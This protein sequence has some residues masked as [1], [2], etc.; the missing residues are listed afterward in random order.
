MQTDTIQRQYDEVIA[1]HYDLDPQ[2][3]TGDSL[4]KAVEQLQST[5]NLKQAESALRI[6]DVGCGTGMFCERLRNEAG[7]SIDPYGLDLSQAMVDIAGERI[8]DMKLAVDDAANLDDHFQDVSFNIICTH[9]MTGFVPIDVL[10]PKIH[11]KL[12]EGGY[13]SF[14]GG[15]MGGFPNLQKKADLK[16]L[17]MIFGGK[18]IDTPSLVSNPQDEADVVQKLQSHGFEVCQSETFQPEVN[19]ANFDEFMDFAYRGGWLTPFVEKLGL[20]KLNRTSQAILNKLAFPIKD[21]HSIVLALA[22]KQNQ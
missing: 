13:W 1:Q 5:E 15:T 22:R 2:N 17:K 12:D 21:H 10:A 14:V 19:F 9:F 8:S 20:H 6:L 11:N 18:S 7:M 3:V 4:D 16:I